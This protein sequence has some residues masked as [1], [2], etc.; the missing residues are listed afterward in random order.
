MQSTP[1]SPNSRPRSLS[2]GHGLLTPRVLY[3]SDLDGTL[4]DPHS[5]VS[6]R[7]A[8]LLNTAIEKGVLFTIATARTPGTV[9][10]L[11]AEVDMRLRGVVMTGAAL[12]DFKTLNYSRICCIAPD[13]VKKMIPVYRKH[14]V[15]TFIYK[16][17]ETQK[18][19]CYHI[20]ELNQFEKTFI[21]ERC[22]SPF[23]TFHVPPSGESVLPATFDNTVLLFSVQPWDKAFALYEEIKE[24]PEFP[25]YPL[26]YHDAFG[27]EWG[28]LEMFSRQ[29]S[30]AAAV[31]AIASQVGAGRIVAFGDNVNDMPLF[32]LADEGFAVEGAIDALK[33]I[34][35]DVIGSNAEDAVPEF[36]FK[37]SRLCP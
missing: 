32:E 15:A 29:T 12:F 16:I 25:V 37:Y 8:Y 1:S 27:S 17:S 4:L 10:D 33:E 30:K 28:E 21:S 22:R 34:A 13:V 7:S 20:G 3:V 24:S 36:I 2:F 5:H 11:L 23:K 14:G 19:D 9:V 26:C 35:T 18:L 6:E 31:E